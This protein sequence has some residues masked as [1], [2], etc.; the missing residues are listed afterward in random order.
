MQ[1]VFAY[2]NLHL[3]SFTQSSLRI[4]N[5]LIPVTT[6]SQKQERLP[7]T[8]LVLQFPV[9]KSTSD[10]P[11]DVGQLTYDFISIPHATSPGVNHTLS[12]SPTNNATSPIKESPLAEAAPDVAAVE[13]GSGT[14]QDAPVP[15]PVSEESEQ[16]VEVAE[17]TADE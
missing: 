15:L 1:K 6:P 5:T 8:L 4:A 13:D 3:M 10:V 16:P 12:S 17:A 9:L 7:R 11:P 14:L 2:V